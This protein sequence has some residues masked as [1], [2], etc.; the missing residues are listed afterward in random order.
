MA[1]RIPE[2]AAPRVV[3]WQELQAE[4]KAHRGQMQRVLG[5]GWNLAASRHPEAQHITEQCQKLEGRWAEL[6]QAC[7]ARAQGLQQA[8]TLQQ[9]GCRGH[10]VRGRSQ[11]VASVSNV[12]RTWGSQ[13][14]RSVVRTR[15]LEL[16]GPHGCRSLSGLPA[17]EQWCDG[18]SR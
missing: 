2:A 6:E 11:S 16:P 7:E 8:A 14:A 15:G 18:L 5:S 13:G 9:V 4:V 17:G 12:C 1:K 3:L 10:G